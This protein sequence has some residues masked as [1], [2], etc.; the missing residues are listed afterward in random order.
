M[1]EL[2]L[3]TALEVLHATIGR[4][5]CR[6][7]ESDGV[8]HAELVLKGADDHLKCCG[9]E[10]G[11]GASG[12]PSR[13][14]NLRK[15]NQTCSEFTEKRL[16][17]W[18]SSNLLSDLQDLSYRKMSSPSNGEASAVPRHPKDPETWNALAPIHLGPS[19]VVGLACHVRRS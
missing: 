8:L 6:V 13:T 7:P 1:F 4:K 17:T 11:G 12:T 10:E 15:E 16:I 14:A 18:R 3:A 19:A 2:R 5:A 9:M